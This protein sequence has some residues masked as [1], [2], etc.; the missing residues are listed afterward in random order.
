[1]SYEEQWKKVD[2]LVKN[3]DDQTQ[4]ETQEVV[5]QKKSFTAAV[6]ADYQMAK[7]LPLWGYSVQPISL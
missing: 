6:D 5:N 4:D 1:M 2:E 3:A 7:L